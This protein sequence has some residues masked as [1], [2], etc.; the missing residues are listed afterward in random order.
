MIFILQSLPLSCAYTQQAHTQSDLPHSFGKW[1]MLDVFSQCDFA[2]S[3]LFFWLMPSIIN[4][5]GESHISIALFSFYYNCN[6]M[7]IPDRIFVNYIS[8]FCLL[9]INV[10]SSCLIIK[11]WKNFMRPRHST[12]KSGKICRYQ[13]GS[14]LSHIKRVSI[15]FWLI[16]CSCYEFQCSSNPINCLLQLCQALL[17]ANKLLRMFSLYGNVYTDAVVTSF[18]NDS[19]TWMKS[20]LIETSLSYY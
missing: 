18:P 10:D 6:A 8:C 9:N 13:K 16:Y 5:A 20:G 4:W 17:L 11:S 12:V 15:A 7:Q 19:S 1:I 14:F 2:I 3:L